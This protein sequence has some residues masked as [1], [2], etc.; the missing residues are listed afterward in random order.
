MK[1]REATRE[2]TH[3]KLIPSPCVPS[4][5]VVSYSFIRRAAPAAPLL[6]VR[7]ALRPVPST[8]PLL[9][10]RSTD[11]RAITITP[12]RRPS[13]EKQSP[14]KN[15]PVSKQTG[16]T[17]VSKKKMINSL[18]RWPLMVEQ[19][20]GAAV[21]PDWSLAECGLASVAGPV[22]VARL[23]AAIPGVTTS[24]ADLIEVDTVGGLAELLG[25]RRKESN[26]RTASARSAETARAD[27][28]PHIELEGSEH[29]APSPSLMPKHQCSRWASL[30]CA[31]WL[32]A[33]VRPVE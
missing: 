29:A 19:L 1:G 24:L 31:V 27:G 6:N 14:K 21:E 2:L 15:Y 10:T 22:L 12:D 33:P 23:Q 7:V 32:S 9:C 3:D 30:E 8:P 17:Q 4:R 5:S 20:T 13:P 28:G 16:S 11:R 25:S 18:P 26:A